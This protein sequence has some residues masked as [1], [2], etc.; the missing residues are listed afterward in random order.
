MSE[1]ATVVELPDDAIEA[2]RSDIASC[3]QADFGRDGGADLL[4]DFIAAVRAEAVADERRR[5]TA[6][7]EAAVQG[8]LELHQC[9]FDELPEANRRFVLGLRRALDRVAAGSVPVAKQ[10]GSSCSE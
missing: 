10:G 4:S 1:E 6:A 8:E 3:L 7:I 2:M 5:A 9:S